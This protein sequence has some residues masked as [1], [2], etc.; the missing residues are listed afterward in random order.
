MAG[1]KMDRG[2]PSGEVPVASMSDRAGCHRVLPTATRAFPS[3][4]LSR[5]FPAPHTAAGR[6]DE[7]VWPTPLKQMSRACRL[8]RKMLCELSARHRTIMLPP[9]RHGEHNRNISRYRQ[10]IP[11][12]LRTIPRLTGTKGI[13]RFLNQKKMGSYLRLLVPAGRVFVFHQ[14]CRASL[15]SEPYRRFAVWRKWIPQVS[16]KVLP[17]G[18]EDPK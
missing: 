1:E 7:P 8:V 4:P 15:S 18:F 14:S 2:E 13:S 9:A 11:L 5:Q 17:A 16:V 6:A 10:A 3:E 12:P